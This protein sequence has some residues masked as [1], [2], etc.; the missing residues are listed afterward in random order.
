VSLFVTFEGTEG[1]GKSSQIR[2]LAE[3]LAS[4]GVHVFATREPGG[5]R[6]GDQVRA[7]V[8]DNRNVE[9]SSNA[10]V[11]LFSAAR[12][13]LVSEEIRPRLEQGT[14]VLSDRYADSTMAYQGYGLELDLESLRAITRFATGGLK[15]D[16]TLL[17]DV[18]PEV[19][20]GRKQSDGRIE[21]NRLDDKAVAFHQRARD[22][23]LALAAAE[24]ERWLVIDAARKFD[25]VQSDIRSAVGRRLGLAV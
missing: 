24:P 2:A 5:T 3:Y 15:P 22:G 11:L 21:W 13:Q 6:I 7:I 10:E 16:L 14:V 25:A 19:G 12:A 23:Y 18:P 20:L 9:M 4:L 1:C 17:L 8:L